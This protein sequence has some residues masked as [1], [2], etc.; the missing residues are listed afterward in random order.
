MKV[1]CQMV[2]NTQMSLKNRFVHKI[3]SRS[4]RGKVLILRISSE[5]YS[6]SSF[7]ALFLTWGGGLKP[8]CA[9][10]NFTDTPDFSEMVV[11]IVDDLGFLRARESGPRDRALS[12]PRYCLESLDA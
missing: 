2:R 7:S 4:L 12:A 5:L 11:F 9:D 1:Q 8:N 6:F 3:A 10:K